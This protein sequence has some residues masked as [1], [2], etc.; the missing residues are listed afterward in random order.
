[1]KDRLRKADEQRTKWVRMTS[2]PPIALAHMHQEHLLPVKGRL[3][4]EGLEF[5]NSQRFLC[6]QSAPQQIST[7]GA[8]DVPSRQSLPETGFECWIERELRRKYVFLLS[9]QYVHRH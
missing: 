5:Q 4:R 9:G 7:I 1:M 6:D 3:N 8:K 2:G